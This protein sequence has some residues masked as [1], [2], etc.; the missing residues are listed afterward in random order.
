MKTS[1]LIK[2]LM[3][4][5]LTYGDREVVTAQK[6]EDANYTYGTVTTGVV[7][8]G[9]RT[10]GIVGEREKRCG[11]CAYY[12]ACRTLSADSKVCSKFEKEILS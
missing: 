9:D 11:D 7:D 8:Y 1:E 2:E 5:L 6:D 3:N 4:H 12:T 10:I